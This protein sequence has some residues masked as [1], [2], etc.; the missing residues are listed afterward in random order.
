MKTKAKPSS[1]ILPFI[2]VV[3]VVLRFETI[4]HPDSSPHATRQHRPQPQLRAR[5]PSS[6]RQGH[7]SR[8]SSARVKSIPPIPGPGPGPL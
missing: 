1:S 8:D 5:C 4:A 6:H 7:Y 2:L 3:V